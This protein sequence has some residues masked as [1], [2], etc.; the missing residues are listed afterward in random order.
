MVVKKRKSAPQA[1]ATPEAGDVVL[2]LPESEHRKASELVF[3]IFR[4]NGA[5]LAAGDRLTAPLGLT[6]ARWQVLGTIA[7]SPEPLT[8]ASIAKTIGVSRQ[9]IRLIVRELE[10]GGMVHLAHNPNHARASLVLLTT[11][12]KRSESAIRALQGPFLT[13][14]FGDL[15]PEQVAAS[16]DLITSLLGRLQN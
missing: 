4:L 13:E 15:D 7:T 6:S 3:S 9:N 8:I 10:T 14:L 2:Q 12:G 11:K 1:T 5:L 16:V